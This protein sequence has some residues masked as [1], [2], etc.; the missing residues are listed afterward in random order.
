[1]PEGSCVYRAFPPGVVSNTHDF[2][3]RWVAH[4][5]RRMRGVFARRRIAAPECSLFIGVYPGHRKSRQEIRNKFTSYSD[6][7]LVDEHTAIL[8]SCAYNLS[9][10]RVDP[11]Y[12]LD[13][14]DEDGALLPEFTASVVCYINESPP[15]AAP[16]AAFVYNQPRLRYEV[17]L[18]H[19]VERDEEIFLYYGKHYLREYPFNNTGADHLFHIIPVDCVLEPD[20]RGVPAPL[21]VPAQDP[22]LEE[23]RKE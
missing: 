12:R 16:Q 2:E 13:P 17:W 3:V 15:G 19:A 6:R 7:H 1:M 22:M 11:G 20:P 18:L 23:G 8:R 9:L 21:L 5:D 14:T 10:D 4:N